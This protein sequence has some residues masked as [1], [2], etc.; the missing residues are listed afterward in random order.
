MAEVDPEFEML[1]AFVDGEL[2]ADEETSLRHRLEAEPELAAAIEALRADRKVRSALW[3]S[4]EPDEATV[5][6]LIDRVD[7]A[8]DRNTVWS[9]RLSRIRTASAAAACIVVGILIGR[10]TLG[11]GAGPPVN[12]V[13]TQGPVPQTNVVNPTLPQAPA[14]QV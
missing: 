4:Y 3:A 1:S 10:I 2:S 13:L 9:Y 7:R 5:Q 14:A 12:P 8:I 6:R 11:P